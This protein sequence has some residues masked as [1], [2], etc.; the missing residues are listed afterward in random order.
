METSLLQLIIPWVALAVSLLAAGMMQFLSSL[1]KARALRAEL[2][3]NDLDQQLQS[4]SEQFLNFER[5]AER[6]SWEME[7]LREER[8]FEAPAPVLSEGGGN[9]QHAIRLAVRGED[10]ESLMEICSISRGE[11]ELL[12]KLHQRGPVSA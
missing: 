1:H 2:Q 12:I 7:R 3:I 11:A 6:A 8:S 5:R 4:L 10:A 9:Y